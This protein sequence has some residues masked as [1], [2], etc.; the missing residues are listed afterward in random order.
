MR[1][2]GGKFRKK[3]LNSPIEKHIRPTNNKVK[4]AVFSIIGEEIN[5]SIFFDL[6]SGSGSVGIEALSRG[7]K[8]VYFNDINKKSIQ[9]IYNNLSQLKCSNYKVLNL[10]YKKA[11]NK[12]NEYIDY[13]YIDAPFVGFDIN[14][15]LKLVLKSVKLKKTTTIFLETPLSEKIEIKANLNIK[16]YKYGRIMIY[17]IT[18]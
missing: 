12:S 1:V 6:F 5:D 2:I 17:K 9:T 14:S 7:A 4:E 18:F 16:E 8:K 10:D 11:I 15:A 3:I 13:I